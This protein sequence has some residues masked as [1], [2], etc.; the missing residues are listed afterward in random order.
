MCRSCVPRECLCNLLLFLRVK[1]NKSCDK[2]M[3]K[4]WVLTRLS[5]VKACG[6]NFGKWERNNYIN[7]VVICPPGVV[8]SKEREIGRSSFVFLWTQRKFQSR[9]HTCNPEEYSLISQT[10]SHKTHCLHC[11]KC[12]V[13]W[14]DLPWDLYLLL[15][16][17]FPRPNFCHSLLHS[18]SLPF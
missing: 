13:T 11:P 18:Y 6:V 16:I 14:F 17:V 1:N 8:T 3:W 15:S 10:L 2:V 5:D 12:K 7:L 4:K 9:K